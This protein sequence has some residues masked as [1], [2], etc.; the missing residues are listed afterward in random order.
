[1]AN[2]LS[3]IQFE[4]KELLSENN[5]SKCNFQHICAPTCLPMD[6]NKSEDLID[7]IIKKILAANFTEIYFSIKKKMKETKSF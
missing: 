6:N 3:L 2:L 4:R 7:F 1:M 5:E